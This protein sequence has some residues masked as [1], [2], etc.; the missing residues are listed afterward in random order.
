MQPPTPPM[1]LM[2][3][4]CS[5]SNYHVSNQQIASVAFLLILSV[6]GGRRTQLG[7]RKSTQTDGESQKYSQTRCK[8]GFNHIDNKSV[9][10]LW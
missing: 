4:L 5:P 10:I 3:F 1:Q 8:V 2:S 6:S 9:N 7:C